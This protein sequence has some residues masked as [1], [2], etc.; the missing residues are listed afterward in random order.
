VL[1]FISWIG[2]FLLIAIYG[3]PV[4]LLITRELRPATVR[5]ALWSGLLLLVT[6]STLANLFIPLRS[7]DA[8][9]LILV[10]AGLSFILAVYLFRRRSGHFRLG[11][12]GWVGLPK[13]G[14]FL[15]A[16]LVV[17]SIWWLVAATRAPTNYD[18]GLY[19]LQSIWYAAEFKVIPGLANLY[20][21]YGFGNSLMPLTAVVTNGPLGLEA[22]QVINGFFFLLLFVEIILRLVSDRR[23]AVG[24]KV[25]VIGLA[26]FVAPMI[27]MADYWVTSPTF[28]TPVAILT[29]ISVAA[30]ADTLTVGRVRSVD[31]VGALF[32]IALAASMRQHYWFLF[33]FCVVIILWLVLRRKVRGMQP[34]LW[35]SVGAATILVIV[36]LV[37]DY[38]LSGWVLYPYKILSFNV[39]WIAPDPAGL[40]DS[41][42]LW[43]RSPTPAYQQMGDGWE[44][45][46]PWLGA[47]LISWVF[48]AILVCLILAVIALSLTRKIWR[49]RSLLVVMAPL[50]LYLITWFFVGAPHVRYSWA[51]LLLLGAVPLAWAWQAIELNQG[52]S[53]QLMN[54]AQVVIGIELIVVVVASANVA[55]PQLASE[56]PVISVEKVPLSKTVDLLVPQGTD[57]CWSNFPVC[58]GMPAAG[59]TLRGDTITEGFRHLPPS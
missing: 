30:L 48:V 17:V 26:V 41:T 22:Y 39:D 34:A 8:I 10:F 47:N 51:P 3:A 6:L 31:V 36:M 54:L 40:I 4:G 59:L 29:L 13:S 27:W 38:L 49:P 44:W 11:L 1:G 9:V 12:R 18:T 20:P 19:H 23:N 21:S 42:K 37:R 35:L 52:K 57:Q 14:W 32:P 43:A 24:T 46:R 7:V 33:S 58:S 16:A 15:V 25:L 45:V 55:L 56:M 5:I 53:F 28:D 50:V 2:L